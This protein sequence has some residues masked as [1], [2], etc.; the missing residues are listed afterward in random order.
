MKSKADNI[1]YPF[2]HVLDNFLTHKYWKFQSDKF[3]SEHCI[4]RCK[5]LLIQLSTHFHVLLLKL[6]EQLA[7]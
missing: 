1:D 2:I 7:L 4:K 5:M 3:Y 6:K